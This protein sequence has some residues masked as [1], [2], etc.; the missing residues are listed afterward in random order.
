MIALEGRT[1]WCYNRYPLWHIA[2][3]TEL[4]ILLIVLVGRV[5]VHGAPLT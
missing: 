3:G 1:K 4:A 2:S 5:E